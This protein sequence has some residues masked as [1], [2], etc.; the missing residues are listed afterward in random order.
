MIK[1]SIIVKCSEE[2]KSRESIRSDGG[3]NAI[4]GQEG[5][6]EEMTSE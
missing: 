6:F 1:K 4:N 5:L 3:T 2:I